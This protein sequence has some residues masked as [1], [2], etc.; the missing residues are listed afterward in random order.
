MLAALRTGP[1]AA[2]LPAVILR[3]TPEGDTDG[4]L[5]AAQATLAP[6]SGGLS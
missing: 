6:G 5:A 1:G 3:P 4:R 2:D